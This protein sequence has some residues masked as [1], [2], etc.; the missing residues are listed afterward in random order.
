MCAALWMTPQCSP[1][2]ADQAGSGV[3]LHGPLQQRQ[4]PYP[5]FVITTGAHA[6]RQT[7]PMDE[8]PTRNEDAAAI[9]DRGSRARAQE[10]PADGEE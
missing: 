10:G 6:A 9:E 8:E 5:R 3:V 1:F 7:P 2:Q 4:T